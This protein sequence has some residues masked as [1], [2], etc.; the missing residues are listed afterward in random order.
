MYNKNQLNFERFEF[1]IENSTNYLNI[2]SYFVKSLMK[3]NNKELLE[4][5]F[6]NHLKFFDNYFIINLLNYYKNQIH[7]SNTNLYPQNNS[8]KFKLSVEVNEDLS[9]FN[10]SYYLFNACQSGNEI[11]VKF[12]LKHGADMSVKDEND[13]IAFF[14]ACES[15]NEYLVK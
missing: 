1:I 15:G 7:I 14:R 12:L 3:N 10:S 9:E 11:I 13:R 5:L 6:K 2:S 4:F 8:E